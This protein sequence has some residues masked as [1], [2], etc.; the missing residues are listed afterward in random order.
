MSHEVA[1]VISKGVDTVWIPVEVDP[2]LE[3]H[4][5]QQLLNIG[6]RPDCRLT[7]TL[8]ATKVVIEIVQAS[9]LPR[10]VMLLGSLV[11]AHSNNVLLLI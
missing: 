3:K 2:I 7:D 6:P 1:G 5:C 8:R 4:L 11:H 9:H 10:L